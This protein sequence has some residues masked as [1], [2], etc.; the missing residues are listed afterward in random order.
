MPPKR[1]K[2]YRTP[3]ERSIDPAA[4]ELL[5]WADEEGLE[6]AFS[7]AE[8]MVPCPIGAVGS[9]CAV[10]YMGPCRL[11]KEGQTGVCGADIDTV[12]ARNYARAVAA[13]A[14]AHSD[15]GRDVA[16][17]LLA[18]AKGEAQ[19]YTIR[20]PFKLKKLAQEL[21]IETEG[22]PVDEVA[23]EVAETCIAMFG[24]QQGE[25]AM[26]ERAPEKRKELWRKL[27]LV[28]RGIDREVV[29]ILHRTHMGDDQDPDHILDQAL[30]AS[31]S[32][33]WGGSMVAT[34]FPGKSASN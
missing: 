9:C 2:R 1:S 5:V 32:D 3:E 24:Q 28:P 20:D 8:Q 11:V 23:I 34:A 30:R 16:F 21:N 25:L 26:I 14:A 18:T 15:H 22:R 6:T 33:G 27:D 12:A 19:G 13:G 29:D 31:L 4:Q 17:T 10:C 7:R